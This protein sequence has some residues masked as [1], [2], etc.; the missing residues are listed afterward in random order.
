MRLYA[1]LKLV[2]INGGYSFGS[3]AIRSAAINR[4][5]VP[6]LTKP[7]W[8]FGPGFTR[9]TKSLIRSLIGVSSSAQRARMA[10]NASSGLP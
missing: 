3:S 4:K 8:Y 1:F 2:I 9:G 6:G 10:S 5:L 7:F